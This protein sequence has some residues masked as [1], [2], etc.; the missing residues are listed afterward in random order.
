MVKNECK[1]C[2]G[3]GFLPMELTGGAVKC[4]DCQE[5]KRSSVALLCFIGFFFA[6][7]FIGALIFLLFFS[8]TALR[9]SP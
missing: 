7:G 8:E 1:T 6:A 2:Y 3:T 4:P 9:F 5:K